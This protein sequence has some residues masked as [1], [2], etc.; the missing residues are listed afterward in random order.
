MITLEELIHVDVFAFVMPYLVKPVHVELSDE[1]REIT[2]LEILGQYD[3][4][5]PVDVRYVEGIPSRCPLDKLFTGFILNLESIS[6]SR[7][8]LNF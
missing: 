1:R 6:T 3:I 8:L 7:I 2:M 5:E 4:S